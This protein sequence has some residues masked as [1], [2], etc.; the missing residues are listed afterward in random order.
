[1]SVFLSVAAI[2]AFMAIGFAAK[3]TF[4][5]LDEK[6]FVN[7]SIYFL[8]PILT[9]WGLSKAPITVDL[10]WV[11]VVYGAIMALLTVVSFLIA[12][13]MFDDPKNRSIVTVAA[14][15]GNTGNLGIPLGLALFG[16]ASLLYTT[17]INLMNVVF[18]YT[19]GVFFYSRGEFGIAQ[20]LA[21]IVKLPVLWLAAVA[22]VL[23]LAGAAYPAPVEDALQMGAHAS[24]VL[25]L[26]I[27]GVYLYSVRIAQIEVRLNAVVMVF[28]F[29][30]VPLLGWLL[31]Q[32]VDLP[33]LIASVILLEL[34]VPL[35]VANVNLASLY[36][37]RPV[38]VTGSVLISSV[39]FVGL[40]PLFI[41][42][43]GWGG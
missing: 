30:I 20:S 16:E 12:R 14:M 41:F 22:V 19:A 27:F 26:V 43:L 39:L 9:F 3:R 25:Q 18:V 5:D 13:M 6:S 24:M 34:V 38:T 29:V 31:L 28:K 21:N 35:A 17:A 37:C 15:I 32:R 10:A 7:L 4:R 42:L 23:N 36:N 2:Y 40:L 11:G 8:Q 33:P 1:M